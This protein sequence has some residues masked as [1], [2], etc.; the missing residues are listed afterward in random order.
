MN[1]PCLQALPAEPREVWLLLGLDELAYEEGARITGVR[2]MHVD[3]NG[4]RLTL[5]IS[6]RQAADPAAGFRLAEEHGIAIFHWVDRGF[7]CALSGKTTRELL[8]PVA[9][10]V[11]RQLAP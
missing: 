1:A 10:T 7:A 5:F 8:L 6:A 3:G 4:E 11:Y 2:F 9:E